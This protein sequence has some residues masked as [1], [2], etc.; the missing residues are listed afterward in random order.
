VVH[1]GLG[2]FHRAHQ[3]VYFEEILNRGD[4]RW[5]ISAISLRRPVTRDALLPQDFLYAMLI[6]SA[7]PTEAQVI[8][9]I[10]ECL[11]APE[12]P[13]AVI[14]RL[15]NQDTKLVTLTITEKGYLENDEHSA[16]A[17]LLAAL[18]RRRATKS[19]VT[20]LSCDNLSSNGDRLHRQL[21]SEAE[22][23]NPQL[24]PWIDRFVTCPNTMVDR[25][26]PATTNEDRVEAGNILG[27]EDAWPVAAEP[28]SQWV[29]E[30]R[31]ASDLPA[32]EAVG[33]QVVD[34]CAPYEAM[35]LRLLNAAHSTLA[36]LGAPAGFMTVDQ[37]AT[38]PPFKAFLRRLWSEAAATLPNNL[39]DQVPAYVDALERR[40]A[41][42]ALAHR[43]EQIAMDGSLK[44][45]VRLL[46]TLRDCL[47]ADLPSGAIELAVAAWLRWL[48]CVDEVGK[49]YTLKDPMATTLARLADLKLRAAQRVNQLMMFE[50][51]F[52]VD[53]PA[54]EKMAT[55]LTGLLEM[56]ESYGTLGA[57]EIQN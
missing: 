33:V 2:N 44:V 5:G 28:F 1:L 40:F 29:I 37:T 41:N 53:F 54:H 7:R 8:G 23:K 12:N 55:R 6:R 31:F 46:A 18:E 24:A 22:R 4:L 34:S 15:A 26:V 17:Y 20:I 21:L 11:V 3:A 10:K 47:S 35:K 42:P 50:P 32:F 48:G 56:L 39:Q 51:V 52:G 57:L 43:L 19:P 14:A 9:A 30:N 16:I 13:E 25:I 38:S 36:Y 27:L 45:P 49:S